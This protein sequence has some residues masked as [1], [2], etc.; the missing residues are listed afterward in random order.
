MSSKINK[1]IE[2]MLRRSKKPEPRVERKGFAFNPN[3]KLFHKKYYLQFSIEW[4]DINK[5]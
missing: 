4:E 2:L 5:E 3:I 1:G